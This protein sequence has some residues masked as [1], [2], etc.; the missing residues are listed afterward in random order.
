M[1]E[2][3]R[4]YRLRQAIRSPFSFQILLAGLLLCATNAVQAE[5]AL[6][7]GDDG[8]V[9]SD[10]AA[11]RQLAVLLDEDR[12]DP[13]GNRYSGYVV[14]RTETI[15]QTGEKPDLAVTGRY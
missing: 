10:T 1:A 3:P 14:W 6:P 15:Q 4:M 9:Q 7:N 12:A 11:S 2:R 13:K 5:T 8:K